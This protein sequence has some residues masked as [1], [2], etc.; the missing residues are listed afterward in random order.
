[1]TTT[2]GH[3]DDEIAAELAALDLPDKPDGPGAAMMIS[4]GIGIFM[5]GLFTVLSEA[6]TGVKD[7]LQKWEWG[8]GVGPLA[9]KTTVATLIYFLSLAVL[10]VIWRNKEINLKTAFYVGLGLGVLGAL[11][12]YPA[13]FQAF[14]P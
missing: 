9:G 14:A 12:T 2:T 7:W 6:S 10:W 8:V 1:M 4:A 5:L 11:G 3:H 13:F